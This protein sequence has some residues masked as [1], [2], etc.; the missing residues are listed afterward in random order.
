MKKKIAALVL[1][2]ISTFVA[3]SALAMTIIGPL[4]NTRLGISR[5]PERDGLNFPSILAGY[6]VLTIFMIWLTPL[7]KTKNWI[8]QGILVGGTSGLS[9]FV[10]GHLIVAGWSIA[11]ATAM[12]LSGLVDSVATIAGGLVIA[13]IFRKHEGK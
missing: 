13:F 4:L 5:D 8:M 3:N 7:V 1:G 12:L 6:F 10:G 9:V 11:D 2:F